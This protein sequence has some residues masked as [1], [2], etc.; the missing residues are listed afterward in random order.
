MNRFIWGLIHLYKRIMVQLG[1]FMGV[2]II[3]VIND[4]SALR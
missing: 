3:F 1:S 4:Y 2:V